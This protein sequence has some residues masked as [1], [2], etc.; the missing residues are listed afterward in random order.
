M[1]VTFYSHACEIPRVSE[2]SRASEIVH[3]C[4]IPRVSEISHALL[5]Q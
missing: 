2:I 4:E 1:R 5:C 3:A